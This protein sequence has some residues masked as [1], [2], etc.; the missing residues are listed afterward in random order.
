MGLLEDLQ[1][2]IAGIRAR[3]DRRIAWTNDGKPIGF[4]FPIEEIRQVLTL[5]SHYGIEDAG[6]FIRVF[7]QAANPVESLVE[8][9]T[10]AQVLGRHTLTAAEPVFAGVLIEAGLTTELM[11]YLNERPQDTECATILVLDQLINTKAHIFPRGLLIFL[12][13][14]GRKLFFVSQTEDVSRPEGSLLATSAALARQKAVSLRLAMPE[15]PEIALRGD[16]ALAKL[17]QLGA[18]STLAETI[19]LATA[20]LTR[21]ATSSELAGAIDRCRAYLEQVLRELRK[22]LEN[23]DL[24]LP[25]IDTKE[26]TAS[27]LLNTV[28]SLLDIRERELLQKYFNFVS[29]EGSHTTAADLEQARLARNLSIEFSWYLLERLLRKFPA[30][31]GD[32]RK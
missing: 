20:T 16:E 10:L 9:K 13:R 2:V 6:E 4:V 8:Y 17:A 21:P 18:P 29:V 19:R 31:M 27:V 7:Q 26:M 3:H 23:A 1:D 28:S 14:F 25:V 22:L 12:Q 24:S 11:A 30:V 32:A 15:A 5:R